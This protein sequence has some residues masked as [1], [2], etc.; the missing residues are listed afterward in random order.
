MEEVVAVG[1]APNDLEALQ[2][3]GMPVAMGN[4]TPEVLAVA[5]MTVAD[6]DHDGIVE[7]VEHLF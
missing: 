4:A 2:A 7:V 3:V 5:R 6:N 1:D